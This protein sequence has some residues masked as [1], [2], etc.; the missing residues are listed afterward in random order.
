MSTTASDFDS[1]WKDALE[2]FFPAFLEF[3][4]SRV[5]AAVD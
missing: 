3:F 5:H 4:F 1:P 2:L